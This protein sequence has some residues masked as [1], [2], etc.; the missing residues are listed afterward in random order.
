MQFGNGIRL[1]LRIMKKSITGKNKEG[2][3]KCI[4]GTC[5]WIYVKSV[6]FNLMQYI[7]K[8]FPKK[9]FLAYQA[10]NLIEKN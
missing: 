8:L 6:A 1:T 3:F 4:L 2:C 10:T 7:K 5:V 9:L